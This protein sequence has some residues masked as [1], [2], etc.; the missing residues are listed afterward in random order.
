MSLFW[1]FYVLCL[2]YAG[3]GLILGKENTRRIQ[4]IEHQTTIIKY[5]ILLIASSFFVVDTAQDL[6][7]MHFKAT[8][9]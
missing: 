5:N 7:Y 3:I 9:N 4:K 1:K 6:Q 8:Y 2:H